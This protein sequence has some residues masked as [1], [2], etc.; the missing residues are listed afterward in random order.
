MVSSNRRNTMVGSALLAV[1]VAGLL[2]AAT[3]RAES[4]LFRN[5]TNAPIVVQA[6]CVVRGVVKRDRPHTLNPGDSTPA[7]QLPGNKVITVYDAKNPN[8]VIYQGAVA[9]GVVDQAFGIGP[10]GNGGVQLNKKQ[11]PG[12]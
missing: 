8:V 10:D 4:L 2:P 5:D 12:P 1:L 9:G 7:V 6:S 3:A 11:M